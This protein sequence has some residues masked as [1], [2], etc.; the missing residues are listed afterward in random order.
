M[1]QVTAF[2]YV[3]IGSNI[4]AT[5]HRRYLRI[6][7]ILF[8]LF[9]IESVPGVNLAVGMSGGTIYTSNRNCN[10]H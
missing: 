7:S 3:G 1:Y 10:Y 6:L 5:R 8:A 2:V 9:H 4:V